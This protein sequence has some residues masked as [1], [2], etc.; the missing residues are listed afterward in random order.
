M[1]L[2]RLHILWLTSIFPEAYLRIFAKKMSLLE[3][4]Q[5]EILDGSSDDISD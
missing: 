1:Y 5:R 3:T 2:V 4:Q